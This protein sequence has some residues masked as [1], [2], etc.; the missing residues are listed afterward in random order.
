MSQQAGGTRGKRAWTVQWRNFQARKNKS[1]ERCAAQLLL[2]GRQPSSMSNP[3]DLFDTRSWSLQRRRELLHPTTLEPLSGS[4]ACTSAHSSHLSIAQ[5]MLVSGSGV[6][7]H[8]DDGKLCVPVLHSAAL[9]L[10]PHNESLADNPLRPQA[11][12]K[13]PGEAAQRRR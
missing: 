4:D 5:Y 13:A 6:T 11:R 2:S 3:A 10:R 7:V 12:C 8:S 1:W 9:P